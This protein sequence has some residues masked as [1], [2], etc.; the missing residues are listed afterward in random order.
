MTAYRPT[1]QGRTHDRLGSDPACRAH[2]VALCRECV[3]HNEEM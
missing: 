3:E 2:E 1:R